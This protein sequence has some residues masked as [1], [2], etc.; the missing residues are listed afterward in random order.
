MEDI[1]KIV[2]LEA[3]VP[4]YQNQAINF[5]GDDMGSDKA[6]IIMLLYIVIVI[7]AFCIW[8]YDQQHDPKRSRCDRYASGFRI[9][10][11]RA[12][13]ALYDTS[14]ADYTCWRI[15]RKYSWIYSI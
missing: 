7:M 5:T 1:G 12:C 2:T 10:Q 6:M 11:K 9:Y 3:F 15:D 8:H 13:H 4:Q 14:G